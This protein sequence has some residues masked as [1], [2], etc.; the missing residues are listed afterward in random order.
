MIAL[1]TL[2]FWLTALVPIQGQTIRAVAVG[3]AIMRHWPEE[4]QQTAMCIGYRESSFKPWETGA[5][6]ERGVF[7]ILLDSSTVPLIRDLGYR[8]DQMW[9]VG[10][11]VHV[12]SEMYRQRGLRPWAAQRGVCW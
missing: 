7:Q 10:P 9:E 4:A 5:L 8:L 11:N 2:L 1:A 6:G 12:A 3:D